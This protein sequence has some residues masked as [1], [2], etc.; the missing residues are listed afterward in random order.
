VIHRIWPRHHD[1]LLALYLDVIDWFQEC[2]VERGLLIE[3]RR[4]LI[5]LW[6]DLAVVLAFNDLAGLCDWPLL[7]ER[8]RALLINKL[9]RHRSNVMA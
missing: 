1:Y 8:R 5:W 9:S 6:L 4:Q 2:W 3:G 7:L